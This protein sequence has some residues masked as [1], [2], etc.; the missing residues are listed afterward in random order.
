MHSKTNRLKG[1]YSLVGYFVNGID[2]TQA[3]NNLLITP[4]NETFGVSFT[5]T[6]GEKLIMGNGGHGKWEFADHKRILSIDMD[7]YSY[8]NPAPFVTR[9]QLDWRITKLTDNHIHLKANYNGND[10]VVQLHEN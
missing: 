5:I 7:N 8:T 2:S 9:E 10:Y 3:L 6:D 1:G 4:Y